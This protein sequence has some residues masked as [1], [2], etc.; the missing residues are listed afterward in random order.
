MTEPRRFLD[1]EG[2]AF[3]REL[4]GSVRGED[5]PDAHRS[6]MALALGLSVTPSLAPPAAPTA[7]TVNPPPTMV[8]LPKSGLG[9][10]IVG[11][12][13]LG[14]VTTVGLASGLWFFTQRPAE[15]AKPTGTQPAAPPALV[16]PTPAASA[17]HAFESEQPAE[18]RDPTADRADAPRTASTRNKTQSG[19]VR[20][21]LDLLDPARAAI[22]RG[23]TETA[24]ALL[25]RYRRRFASGMLRHEARALE[26]SLESGVGKQHGSAP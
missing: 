19:D 16:V 2:T 17:P 20:A 6:R 11:K 3:E 21:E 8:V 14:V 15:T 12:A 10:T 4:L 18:A 25:Q 24:R 22:A 23:D 13:L 7:T 26:S 5:V 9:A 1:G